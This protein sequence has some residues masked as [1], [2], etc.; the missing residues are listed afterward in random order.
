MISKPMQQVMMMASAV[1]SPKS[2]KQSDIDC[3]TAKVNHLTAAFDVWNRW[4]LLGLGI[5]AL[6]AVW[7]GITSRMAYVRSKQLAVAQDQLN[8]AKEA[9]LKLD[10]QER[11]ERIADANKAAGD[12]NERAALAQLELARLTGP[13]YLVPVI[14]GTATPDL[15]KGTKQLVLLTSETRINLPKLPDGKSLTWTL[16][17]AQDEVGQHQ[18]TFSPQISG[19]GNPLS[20]PGHSKWLVNLLTDSSGTVNVGLGGTFTAAPKA[21]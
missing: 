8:T 1:L 5:A 20:S 9:Q 12:A 19:F 13:A 7:I 18:F 14:H 6:A 4:I 15:S 16:I 3:L 17:L 11:D 10:L 2:G 21:P